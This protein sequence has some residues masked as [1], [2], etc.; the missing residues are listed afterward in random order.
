MYMLTWTKQ[1]II[2]FSVITDTNVNYELYGYV[3]LTRLSKF[4]V[5]SYKV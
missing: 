3:F 4:H 2:T 1:R 5:W